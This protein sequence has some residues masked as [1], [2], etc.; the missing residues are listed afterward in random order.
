MIILFCIMQDIML[1]WWKCDYTMCHKAVED[2]LCH[3]DTDASVRL[4]LKLICFFVAYNV[5]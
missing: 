5:H 2:I 1:L 3:L 4:K